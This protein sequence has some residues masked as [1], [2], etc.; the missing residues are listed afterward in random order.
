VHVYDS[1]N[2]IHAFSPVV[3]NWKKAFVLQESEPVWASKLCFEQ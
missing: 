2:K 1:I 3:M